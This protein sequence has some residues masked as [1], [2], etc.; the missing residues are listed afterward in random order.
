MESQLPIVILSFS[1]GEKG[2][3]RLPALSDEAE[4]LHQLFVPLV[5]Q[6][7]I[8]LRFY[9]KSTYQSLGE[10]LKS[11]RRQVGVWHFG[12]H[13]DNKRLKMVGTDL[14]LSH[15]APL[16]GRYWRPRLVFLNGCTTDGMV[17]PL[18]E[19]G[20]DAVIASKISVGDVTAACFAQHFYESWVR[21]N[22]LEEAFE[23]AIGLI[24]ATDVEATCSRHMM[25]VGETEN[26]ADFAI[27]YRTKDA[28]GLRF[29]EL[30]RGR[31]KSGVMIALVLVSMILL[32]A[33]LILWGSAPD[34]PKRMLKILPD[35][36]LVD[37]QDS[38]MHDAENVKMQAPPNAKRRQNTR[39]E[40]KVVIR[41]TFGV[42][43]DFPPAKGLVLELELRDYHKSYPIGSDWT[44][45]IQVP[46]R[47]DGQLVQL[48]LTNG[49]S[50]YSNP[51][52]LAIPSDSREFNIVVW[53]LVVDLLIEGYELRTA[54]E[55]MCFLMDNEQALDSF[56]LPMLSDRY[57]YQGLISYSCIRATSGG[58]RLETNNPYAIMKS[59]RY[60]VPRIGNEARYTS[61]C[62][63]T[64][65][66]SERPLN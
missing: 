46:E 40:L 60:N 3:A 30:Y 41:D 55:Y 21:G 65:V 14:T 44:V 11:L 23:L 27:Y 15:L 16:I 35:F 17:G 42:P 56:S 33:S 10:D 22:T 39:Q 36:Q 6:G 63:C 24:R 66:L 59:C 32:L 45:H 1:D 20:V 19:A 47:G 62:E 52:I 13:A 51:Q 38:A 7:K 50:V 8:D 26:R 49:S 57:Q 18:V 9:P 25:M 29:E 64:L 37:K 12:G 5:N 58:L 54:S 31:K 43:P 48:F 4:Q 53:P 2:Q 61:G 34:S 28:P